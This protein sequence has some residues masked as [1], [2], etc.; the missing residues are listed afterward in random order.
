MI[1]YEKVFRYLG[2]EKAKNSTNLT[3]NEIMALLQL[4]FELGI[5]YDKVSAYN[6]DS[7]IKKFNNR[8]SYKKGLQLFYFLQTMM[9]LEPNKH[10]KP[11][12]LNKMISTNFRNLLPDL[13]YNF[14]LI[15]DEQFYSIKK[16]DSNL[17]RP[18]ELTELLHIMTDELLVLE[19]I[20]GIEYIKEKNDNHPGRKEK[21]NKKL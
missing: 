10:Y 14:G 13:L 8:F 9:T 1:N 7:Y 16:D 5:Q 21:R 11:N 12:K 6:L 15:N 2:N 3:E 17:I 4:M 19:K 20:Q 18:R